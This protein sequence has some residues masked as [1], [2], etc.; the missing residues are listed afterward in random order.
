MSDGWVVHLPSGTDAST[1]DLLALESLPRAWAQR[2]QEAP[3]RPAIAAADGTWLSYGELDARSRTVAGRLAA[4]GLRSG[5]RILMSAGASPEL[6][7][8]YV[9]AQRLGL[10]V[11]PMNT[12]YTRREVE[13]IL[14]DA[15]P[16]AAIVDD[17][18]RAAWVRSAG[19]V[20]GPAVELP[21]GPEPP[22]DL[23]TRDNLAVIAYTSGTTGAPKGAMLTSGNLLASAQAVRLAWRWSPDDRLVLA[24]PLF[25]MHGLGVGITGTL[26]AGASAV[27]LAKFDV[28]AVLDVAA[29]TGATLFFG[30]PTM[31]A[32]LAASPRIGELRRLRLCVSGSAPL[33]ADLH[34]A[35]ADRAGQEVIERYGMTETVMN[36]STPYDGDRRAGSVGL[37]LPG[38]DVRLLENGEIAVRGPNVFPGYWNRPEATDAAFTDDGWFRTGDL[39]AFD[40]D[41][42]LR[43]V[44]R[45][46]DLIIT[47]GYNVYPREVEEVVRAHPRVAD[48]AV[49]GLPSPEWGETVAAWVVAT[50]PMEE[51][52][53]LEFAAE[54]LAAY[55]RPRIVRFLDD[56]P[57]NALG[58]VVKAELPGRA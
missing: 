53:L 25:H 4:A 47:G 52:E 31:Y 16:A 41:G 42:Y 17:P 55:K 38:V 7:V 50:E 51:D 36:V 21:E 56:L 49:A 15:R 44:G 24:L 6:V 58:K 39:G 45:T 9:A 27:L 33:P 35:L 1:L 8:A 18:D 30:V 2:F 20:C 19:V 23:A 3:D 26:I 14:A 11:V 57:R 54:H 32:R 43:I 13:H 29:A 48:V 12:S 28:E 22:L 5:E 10:V 46:K 40:G 37:A 34:R